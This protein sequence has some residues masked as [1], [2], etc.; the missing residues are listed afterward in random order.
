[1]HRSAPR[2]SRILA[3]AAVPV[4]LVVAGCS[5][6]SGDKKESGSSE[7]SASASASKKAE[8][9]VEPAKFAALPDP[10]KSITKKTVTSLVPSAKSKNGTATTSSDT[11]YRAGCSWNGLDDNGV[12]GSQ[13][14]WLDVGFTRF[15]S[16]QALGSGA[17]RAQQDFT[18]QVA[19]AKATGGAKKVVE[20]P[21]SGIGEQATKITYDL[22][23]TSED[24]EYATVVARTGNVV[25][26]LTYNGAG[27]AG[28]KAPS[29]GDILKGAEKAAKEAVAA[30]AAVDTDSAK[31]S[32]SA[33]PDKKTTDKA[34][35]PKSSDSDSSDRKTT[36]KK[37][38]ASKSS[39]RKTS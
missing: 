25:V 32:G 39:V 9:T 20:A 18:K 36:D 26:T 33:T 5:S 23:K 16:D 17:K 2:L 14:R 31:P 11:A 30:V 37:S 3:C 34:D 6:D 13:Y 1:M 10:C 15:D 27:Y 29:A 35:D 38:S 21:V 7:S 12:K 28:A 24:F 8:P 19:K 4:M 22:T